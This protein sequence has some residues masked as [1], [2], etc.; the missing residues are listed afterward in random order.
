MS[1]LL[2]YDVD[3]IEEVMNNHVLGNNN[4]ISILT[5]FKSRRTCGKV[6]SDGEIIV[7]C[8]QCCVYNFIYLFILCRKI[9]LVFTVLIVL[10]LKNIKDIH[11]FIV[12]RIMGNVIVEMKNL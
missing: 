12:M 11:I 5:S 2:S 8:Q 10:K 1:S 4:N 6:L 9:L 3:M 7:Y